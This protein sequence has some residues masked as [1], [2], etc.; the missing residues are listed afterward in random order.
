MGVKNSDSPDD[1][2]SYHEGRI[3]AWTGNG[4]RGDQRAIYGRFTDEEGKD[5]VLETNPEPH[6]NKILQSWARPNDNHSAWNQISEAL[7]KPEDSKIVMENGESRLDTGEQKFRIQNSSAL[8]ISGVI[9]IDMIVDDSHLGENNNE[10]G[11]SWQP[12]STKE[13]DSYEF[14]EVEPVDNVEVAPFVEDKSVGYGL[15]L[16]SGDKSIPMQLKSGTEFR[17]ALYD[18]LIESADQKGN[19]RDSANLDFMRI[20]SRD[21]PDPEKHLMG[22]PETIYYLHPE[23]VIAHVEKTGEDYEWKFFDQEGYRVPSEVAAVSAVL[24]DEFY[25]SQNVLREA[26]NLLETFTELD[27]LHSKYH[28]NGEAEFTGRGVQ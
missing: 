12:F 14:E 25:V 2:S 28:D 27:V 16:N 7:E 15:I 21:D 1:D 19:I 11:M 8:W 9:D 10:D 17:E 18:D 3:N 22:L 4:E 5:F 20:V 6:E 23:P 24:D 13:P 26:D